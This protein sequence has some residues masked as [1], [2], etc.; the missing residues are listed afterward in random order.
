MTP[1]DW[2]PD[3][4][5]LFESRYRPWGRGFLL[6]AALAIGAGVALALGRHELLGGLIAS[7]GGTLGLILGGAFW[8]TARIAQRQLDA[9]RDH[10]ALAR[11]RI[12]RDR[13]LTWHRTRKAGV[14]VAAA[15]VAGL[16]FAAGLVAAALAYDDGDTKAASFLTLGGLVVAA[17]TY[18]AL[19]LFA[20]RPHAPTG[21]TIPLIIGPGGALTVGE[22]IQW[23]GFGIRFI[24]AT[25]ESSPPTLTVRFEMSGRYGTH[26]HTVP[27]PVPADRLDDAHRVADRLGRRLT[28]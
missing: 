8:F 9:L 13:W 2:R 16:L 1:P 5:P 6:F 22:Y 17:V 10:H 28:E 7:I 4:L 21:D 23:H 27:L 12:D 20:A 26:T 3:E 14:A 19:R 25:V 11:W 18:T 15:I 24:D